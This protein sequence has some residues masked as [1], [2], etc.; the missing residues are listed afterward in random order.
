MRFP[1]LVLVFLALSWAFVMLY[2]D[3][4][5]LVRSIRNIAHPNVDPAAV[6][7]IARRLPNDPRLI[8]AYVLDRQVPYA[9]DWQTAGVPW[10]F[11]T[12]REVLQ[13]GRGDCESRAM[14]LASILAAKHI[15]YS[16]KLS[17]DHIWVDY[18]GKTSNALE[19]PGVVFAGTSHGHFFIHWP[20]DFHLGAEIDAQVLNYWTPAPPYRVVLLF[21]G[22]ELIMLWNV[23]A[24][25]L[26]RSGAGPARALDAPSRRRRLAARPHRV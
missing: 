24:A 12:T 16:L 19:N 3:P 9:Y 23:A 6:A 7:A 18:P 21:A 11:P 20:K 22:L 15:P 13:Q 25:W 2:P 1:R 8:E 10:Y 5:V 26:A 4:T 14:M 17:F